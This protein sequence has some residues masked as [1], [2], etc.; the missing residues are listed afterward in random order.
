MT[1]KLAV[2]RILQL[3]QER[4]SANSHTVRLIFGFS[5][6][7]LLSSSTLVLMIYLARQL[8]ID[9]FGRFS[10]L[11]TGLLFATALQTALITQPHHIIYPDLGPHIRSAYTR[12]LIFVQ[13]SLAIVIVLPLMATCVLMTGP[14]SYRYGLLALCVTI[15]AYQMQE[16]FRRVL[17]SAQKS[18]AAFQNDLAN[19]VLQTSAI[20]TLGWN[21]RLTMV[22]ALLAMAASSTIAAIIGY[23]Q[24]NDVSNDRDTACPLLEVIEM[25][26]NHGRWLLSSSILG[27]ARTWLY[28][29]ATA[30]MVGAGGVAA[31]RAIQTLLGPTGLLI[32]VL[33]TSCA[34]Q[35]ARV[36]S[37]EG[38][39]GVKRFTAQLLLWTVP[40][41]V[42]FAIVVLVWAPELL[43][44]AFGRQYAEYALLARMM[45]LANVVVFMQT[46][47]V[48]GLR[49][50]RRSQAIF[51][52]MT[53]STAIGFTIGLSLI[54][55]L[56][57]IGLGI[58]QIV[59][60]SVSL[61]ILT[62]IMRNGSV[63]NVALS[64]GA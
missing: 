21:S 18:K 34:P 38:P 48:I 49:A 59:T 57:L 11:Y 27:S 51:I 14:S 39:A 60:A 43:T 33:D 53:V 3:W 13:L 52:S 7:A 5:D 26:W 55:G 40:V 41:I 23:V 31:Y 24:T 35:V 16:F 30:G 4:N 25:H 12:R 2:R 8:S 47:I 32:R 46:P 63:W 29:I 1:G 54:A 37:V 56:G 15:L 9:E 17:Y 58:T 6:E 62:L 42:A 19:V 10:L 20:V 36:W 44:L 45:A 22:S 61:T 64:T 50:M 28:P